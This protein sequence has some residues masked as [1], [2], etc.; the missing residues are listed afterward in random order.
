MGGLTPALRKTFEVSTHVQAVKIYPFELH[1]IPTACM[2]CQSNCSNTCI[3]HVMTKKAGI[4]AMVG[5][6][7]RTSL[8]KTPIS[9]NLRCHAHLPQA[10]AYSYIGAHD[11]KPGNKSAGCENDRANMVVKPQI[12]T[13]AS[14]RKCTSPS[15]TIS[16]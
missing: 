8:S 3:S 12:S 10:Y 1:C 11:F 16:S 15:R 7:A 6:L 2:T 4:L 13:S 5:M 9:K 14:S